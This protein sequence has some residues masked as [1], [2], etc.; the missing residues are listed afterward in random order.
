LP[1]EL[2]VRDVRTAVRSEWYVAEDTPERTLV[3]LLPDGVV[4]AVALTLD[5]RLPGA[6]GE[7]PLPRIVVS[8][9]PDQKGEIVVQSDPGL[10]VEPVSASGL[11]RMMLRLTHTW[12]SKGQRPLARLAYRHRDAVFQGVVR[13][14]RRPTEVTAETITNIRVS[15]RTVE[16]TSLL[17]FHVSGGG[18]RELRFELPA[19]QAEAEISCPL[20]RR[21]VVQV[22]DQVARVRLELQDEVVGEIKVLVRMD[23]V[24]S[25][26]EA[27]AVPPSVTT[28]RTVRRI[29]VAESAGRDEVVVDR[30][31]SVGLE[32]LSQQ[33]PH[34]GAVSRLLGAGASQAFLVRGAETAPQMALR[35]QRREAVETAGARI[36]LARTVLMIDNAGAF[37]GTQVFYMDNRTEQFLEIDVPAGAALW[38][39]RVGQQLVK[40]VIMDAAAPRRVSVPLVKTAAGDLDYTVTLKYGGITRLPRIGGKITFPVIRPLN[41]APERSQLELRLPRERQWFQFAG[42]MGLVGSREQFQA[43]YLAYQNMQAKRLVQVLQSSNAW[44]KKRATYNLRKLKGEMSQPTPLSEPTG[45]LVVENRK[46]VEQ[47]LALGEKQIAEQ[48]K[49]P[50]GIGNDMAFKQD[51][52]KQKAQLAGKGTA[53][54]Y[55]WN[56]DALPKPKTAP[57]RSTEP[58]AE[59]A[60]KWSQ[61]KVT[62][63]KRSLKSTLVPGKSSG[64]AVAQ[65]HWRQG[66]NRALIVQNAANAPATKGAQNAPLHLGNVVQSDHRS[67]VGLGGAGGAVAPGWFRDSLIIDSSGRVEKKA[68]G[69]LVDNNDS[70]MFL[71]AGLAQVGGQVAD[72]PQAQGLASL[73]VDFPAADDAR[74]ETIRLATPRG[75]MVVTARGV[76]RS[77]QMAAQRLGLCLLA[78][79]ATAL[80]FALLVLLK[81]AARRG[82]RGLV[83]GLLFASLV[84]LLFGIFPVVGFLLLVTALVLKVSAAMGLSATQQV[85]PH[86]S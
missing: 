76:G 34:W 68:L 3:V 18:A 85:L 22:V 59:V 37:R 39:A 66:Q 30:E 5:G 8:G 79:A 43:G 74:W 82:M 78:F 62:A 46:Q 60:W 19:T 47:T 23:R 42:T 20:L 29:L 70:Y 21:K 54:D 14:Q 33:S 2:T 32:P 71:A 67:V 64:Q 4:G 31:T 17:T 83:K 50:M 11:E 9:M 49:Q 63:G 61:P 53:G 6:L 24:R 65:R 73:D 69:D 80:P 25:G 35:I 38:T 36:G 27:V 81:R 12:L 84:S 52:A 28:G 13:V 72:I 16:E 75:D 48:K 58:M 51:F 45:K 15:D 41:V 57:P 40:P 26:S 44:A 7:V 56:A 77:F 1:R 55:N 86:R 10:E